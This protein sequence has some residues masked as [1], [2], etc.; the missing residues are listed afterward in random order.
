MADPLEILATPVEPARPSDAFAARLRTRIERAL[1]L[2]EGVAVSEMTMS[3][4]RPAAAPG[5]AGFPRPGALPYLTVG[6][7]RAA[8]A[9]YERVF[10]A[11]LVGEPYAMPDGRI[12]HAELAIGGGT[13]YL[14]EE[15]PEMGLRAPSEGVTAVSLMLPVDDT[16]ATLERVRVAGGRIE[17]EPYEEYGQRNASLVDPFG[18]RWMLAGPMRSTTPAAAMSEGGEP[19]RHG[20]IGFVSVNVPDVDRA[21]AFYGAVL[22]WEFGPDGRRVTNASMPQGLWGEEGTPTLFCAYAVDSVDAAMEVIRT[23]GGTATEPEDRPYGRI[24]EC[25]DDQGMAFAV[26]EP[27]PGNARPATNG[28]RHGDLAYVTF[29]VVDSARA[30]EFYGTVLG[31]RFEPGRIEDGWG[32]EGPAPMAGLA[33]G[34][35]GVITPMWR[36]DDI[37][38][39]VGRVR[40]AGGTATDPAPQPYGLASECT[41][42]QGTAFWLGQL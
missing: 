16:D 4:P 6:D 39:A 14:A 13:L 10:A 22:G 25:V 1:S 42:D 41:D 9:W 2:P 11:E 37:G 17:R 33:G 19:I 26:Y 38:A 32:V 23:A 24:S 35:A 8:I 34:R 20:D 36:V 7:A 3:E 30:R 40:E 28:S 21:R 18:H 5:P 27:R 29:D 15:F 12:G 31:W